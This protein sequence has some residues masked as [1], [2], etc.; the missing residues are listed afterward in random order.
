MAT[1]T[2]YL[3]GEVP[4]KLKRKTPA[5]KKAFDAYQRA[6]REEDR[7]LGSVFANPIGAKTYR[8]KTEAAYKE[9]KRLEMTHEH[10][11]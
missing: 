11:L 10:G 3:T 6:E 9:C 8:E 1:L 2:Q 4:A 7:Y 5:Q